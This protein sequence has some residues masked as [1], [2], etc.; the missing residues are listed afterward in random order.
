LGQYAICSAFAGAVTLVGA[1]G[2]RTDGSNPAR[3]ERFFSILRPDLLVNRL[4]ASPPANPPAKPPATP[5]PS[6]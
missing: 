5:L 4:L 3:F 1:V 2:K 6:S